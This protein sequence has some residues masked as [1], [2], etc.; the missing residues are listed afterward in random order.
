MYKALLAEV[1]KMVKAQSMAEAHAEDEIY[2]QR[3][4]ILDNP[5]E[6]EPTSTLNPAVER[7][8]RAW[9]RAYTTAV[10]AQKTKYDAE[11]LA[12]EAYRRAMPMLDSYENIR[13]FIACTAFGMLIEV[14]T[15]RAA[16]KL[17]YAAQVATACYT[18]R[19]ARKSGK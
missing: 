10:A 19:H 8:E 1:S 7:C 11:E 9:K 5:D 14:I 16:S 6:P 15:E 18:K 12:N 4:N 17:M 2:A 3:K 13:D